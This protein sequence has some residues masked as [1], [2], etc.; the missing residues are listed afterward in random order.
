MDAVLGAYRTIGGRAIE[1]IPVIEEAW[2]F[3]STR[4]LGQSEQN[5]ELPD[6]EDVF[7]GDEPQWRDL[8]SR[9]FSIPPSDTGLD[10]VEG[11]VIH[12]AIAHAADFAE[13]AVRAILSND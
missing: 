3:F 10:A 4:P 11:A 1:A 6:I 9:Y 7:D 5:D 13:M 2:A 12:Y 8:N